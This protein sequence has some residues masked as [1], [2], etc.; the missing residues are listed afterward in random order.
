MAI[1]WSQVENGAEIRNKISAY[2]T[3]KMQRIEHKTITGSTQR[4]INLNYLPSE[5]TVKL[6]INHLCYFEGQHFNV[7]RHQTRSYIIWTYTTTAGG[8]S[9]STTDRITAEYWTRS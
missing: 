7:V 6:Y 4:E 9:L 5:E 1:D 2:A 3:P 8:F